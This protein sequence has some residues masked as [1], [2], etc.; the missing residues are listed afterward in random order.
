MAASPADGDPGHRALIYHSDE[1]F[2][3][4]TV[5]FLRAGVAAGAPTMAVLPP[6]N[7]ERA[8]ESLG[9]DATAVEWTD[10]ADWYGHPARTLSRAREFVGDGRARVLGEPTWHGRCA[11]ERTEWARL[12]ALLNLALPH[13]P[14]LCAYD[15]RT[16]GPGALAVAAHTHP[17]TAHETAAAPSPAFVDPVDYVRGCDVDPLPAVPDTAR[18]LAFTDDLPEVRRFVEDVAREA[19]VGHDGVEGLVMAVNEAAT[20]AIEHGGGRGELRAWTTSRGLVC[21]VANPSGRITDPLAGYLPPDPHGR[22]GRGLWLMRQLTDLVEIRGDQGVT[23]RIHL[24]RDDGSP[25]T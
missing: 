8:A 13:T 22:R 9:A 24:V 4:A 1:E 6:G 16:I 20:N 7:R 5:P 3:G 19:A 23:V 2:L 15:A 18:V 25:R 21:Q 10:P 11:A 12:E 17:A 14:M